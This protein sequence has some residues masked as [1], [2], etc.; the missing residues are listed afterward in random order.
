[1]NK[2]FIN[3][4]LKDTCEEKCV[5]SGN[6]SNLSSR[7]SKIFIMDNKQIVVVFTLLNPMIIKWNK[8]KVKVKEHYSQL[9]GWI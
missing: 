1:M 4:K 8:T 2:R 7:K 9:R 3:K 6:I 5:K